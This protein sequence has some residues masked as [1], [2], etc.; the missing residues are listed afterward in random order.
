MLSPYFR[1]A[2]TTS[3][4]LQSRLSTKVNVSDTSSMLQPYLRDADTTS[5]LANYLRKTTLPTTG[6]SA[7]NIL[8]WD[9]SKW[10]NLPIGTPGQILSVSSTGELTWVCLVTN[11]AGTASSAPTIAVNNTLTPITIA[12]TGATGIGTASALPSGVTASWSSN[13]ITI[14]GT[15]SLTGTFNFTIPLTGGCGSVNATGTITVI[16]G[17]LATLTTTAV[18][19]ITSTGASSGGNISSD[20]GA[21]VTARGVVWGTTS[22]PTVALSTKTTNGTGSGSFTST[23]TSLTGSTTYYVRAYATNSVGTAYGSELSFTTLGPC[24]SSVTD[25]DGNSY[26][27]VSIGTQCWT[28][29]NLRVRRYNDGTQIRFDNSGGSGGTS[30]STWVSAGTYGAHTIYNHDSTSTT[31][32]LAIYGYLYN[33]YAAAGIITSGGSVTKNICPS[34]WHVPSETEWSTLVQYLDNS[35]S[36]MNVGI[37]SNT[38]GGYM[39]STTGWNSPNTGA[40]NSSGFSA[41]PGGWRSSGSAYEL[42]GNVANFWS[43]TNNP[44]SFDA[45]GLQVGASTAEV[46]RDDFNRSTGLSIRCLKD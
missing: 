26:N 25:F 38:A 24:P 7:G 29:A 42:K 17:M 22:S 19:T 4:N 9:G 2:D 10:V 33:W 27:T 40:N 37:Q 20:G 39:K 31:G 1:D 32:N 14:S 28:S 35:A 43:S 30:S 3:L 18:S 5:M 36:A 41:L 6:L 8:H 11:T 23:L 46:I 44:A 21:P 45:Y 15:P 34:G 13:L 12:T 16:A